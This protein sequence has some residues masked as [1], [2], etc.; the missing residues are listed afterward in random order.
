MPASKENKERHFARHKR[1]FTNRNLSDLDW[2]RIR[3]M[4]LLNIQRRAISREEADRKVAQYYGEPRVE[5]N[6][7]LLKRVDFL[8][9]TDPDIFYE[10]LFRDGL[11]VPNE[12]VEGEYYAFVIE[13]LGTTR[14]YIGHDGKEHERELARKH[15]LCDG[16]VFKHYG[17]EPNKK[18]RT[19][20]YEDINDLTHNCPN[21][22]FMSPFTF[23][24]RGPVDPMVRYMHALAIDLDDL[25]MQ[26]GRPLG[27]RSLLY[28]MFVIDYLP[29][30][31]YIVHSGN[32]LHLYYMLEEP[33]PMYKGNQR[34]L[35]GLRHKLIA[36]IWNDQVTD[37]YADGDIQWE[38]LTQGFRMVGTRTKAAIENGT[39][40]KV[41][42]FK[43]ENGDSDCNRVSIE[44][45]ASF[46]DNSEAYK[47]IKP[48]KK[49]SLK[50]IKEKF[51]DWYERH[52]TEAGN[53]RKKP[54]EKYWKC[55]RAVY[56]WWKDKI[57]T[58]AKPGHRYFCLKCL[59]AYALKCQIPLE[60]FEQDCWR[61]Y[62]FIA[63]NID[64]EHGEFKESDVAQA[65]RN[66]EHDYLAKMSIDRISADSGIEIKKNKRNGRPQRQHLKH[67]RDDQ[68]FYD[69]ENGTNWRDGNGRKPKQTIVQEWR[70]S[71]PGGKKIDCERDTGLSRHTVLKWWDEV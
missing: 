45:L 47:K 51:P 38:R 28:Q 52:F 49:M 35:K 60:E 14:K 29:R 3:E 8:T 42:A 23:A 39:D 43:V 5:S 4:Q 2:E 33:I 54:V 56:D 12:D 7:D 6:R 20:L 61:L 24:G 58:G 68:E 69:E 36:K 21:F 10:H 11:A 55:N 64:K 57:F 53:R 9:E 67:I 32:G 63:E 31:S 50:Q 26:D 48:A 1:Q 41:L 66:Y 40:E 13:K 19:E 59:A 46:V 16:L 71:H 70:K 62:P 30:P 44:Y 17:I 27:L 25:N 37:D 15:Y 65:I 34:L 22:C 18:S